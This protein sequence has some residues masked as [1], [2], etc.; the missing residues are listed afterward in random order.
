MFQSVS[1]LRARCLG[2]GEG[3]SLLL[4]LLLSGFMQGFGIRLGGHEHTF[5]AVTRA[6]TMPPRM[7]M[8]SWMTVMGLM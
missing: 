3:Q 5:Q 7:V 2:S 8:N 6:A 1:T 4:C